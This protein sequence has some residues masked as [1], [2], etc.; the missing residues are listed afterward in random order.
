MSE[1]VK[2][3]KIKDE[4]FSCSS[5]VNLISIQVQQK[6]KKLQIKKYNKT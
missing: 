6:I 3:F 2:D 4:N 1:F 5:G